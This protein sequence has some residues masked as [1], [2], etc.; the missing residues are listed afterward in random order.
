MVPGGY[1]INTN[2]NGKTIPLEAQYLYR[3]AVEMAR[4]GNYETALN[5]L[6]GGHGSTLFFKGIQ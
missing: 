4:R 1:R 3:K 6:T 2:G 5:Y